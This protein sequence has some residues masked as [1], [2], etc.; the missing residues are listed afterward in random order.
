MNMLLQNTAESFFPDGRKEDEIFNDR[1]QKKEGLEH[2]VKKKKT[3]MKRQRIVHRTKHQNADLARE[4]CN[5]AE[6]HIY[7]AW[8]E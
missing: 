6:G 1:K 3:T 2:V 4:T 8:I 5:A 7:E